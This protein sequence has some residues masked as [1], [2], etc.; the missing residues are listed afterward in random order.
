MVRPGDEPPQR[1]QAAGSL[2]LPVDGGLALD[3]AFLGQAPDD[4]HGGVPVPDILN[5]AA[6]AGL[7]RVHCRHPAFHHQRDEIV[8]A[9]VGINEDNLDAVLLRKGRDALVVGQHEL[10]E[11]SRR[12][13]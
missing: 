2:H 8:D 4:S 11:H 5:T 12:D 7:E 10:A 13:Q 6:G 1:D 9:P 3:H